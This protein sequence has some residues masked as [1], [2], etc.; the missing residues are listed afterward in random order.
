MRLTRSDLSPQ[1]RSLVLSHLLL[2][3]GVGN[4]V[5]GRGLIESGGHGEEGASKRKE[6]DDG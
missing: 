1:R 5:V 4:R 6:W 2:L 3:V